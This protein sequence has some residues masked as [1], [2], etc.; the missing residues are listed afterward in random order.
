MNREHFFSLAKSILETPTA[1]FHERM[2]VERLQSYIGDNSLLS[3]QFDR[4]GNYIVKY[5]HPEIDAAEVPAIA[6][7]AHMDHPGFEISEVRDGLVLANMYGW[8]TADH[9]KGSSV[10]V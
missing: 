3:D 5:C 2:V 1:P 6:A 7:I 9:F 4:Y 10:A 8:I